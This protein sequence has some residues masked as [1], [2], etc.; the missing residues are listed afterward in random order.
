MLRYIVMLHYI[1]R[2][3]IMLRYVTLCYAIFAICHIILC[4]ITLL[5]TCYATLCY[6]TYFVA[7]ITLLHNI[8]F[9]F[10][11]HVMLLRYI[12]FSLHTRDDYRLLYVNDT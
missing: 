5:Q 8:T 9:S 10:V 1:I 6:I 4:Y 11:M 3:Y 7:N 2:R 12:I